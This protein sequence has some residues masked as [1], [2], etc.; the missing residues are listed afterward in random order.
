MS[1]SETKKCSRCGGEMAPGILSVE[2]GLGWKINWRL[3]LRHLGENVVAFRCRQCGH[4]E[5]YSTDFPQGES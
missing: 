2:S 5:L 1:Q 3:K 4:V